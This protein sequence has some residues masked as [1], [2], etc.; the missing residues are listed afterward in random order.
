[1]QGQGRG[2]VSRLSIFSLYFSDEL[3][4]YLLSQREAEMVKYWSPTGYGLQESLKMINQVCVLATFV[5]FFSQMLSYA[6]Y[7]IATRKHLPQG[8]KKN[9]RF[10]GKPIMMQE[11]TSCKNSLLLLLHHPLPHLLLALQ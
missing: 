5:F 9:Q 7:I 2:S 6:I 1:M 4:L 8:G 10:K 3:L 11:T